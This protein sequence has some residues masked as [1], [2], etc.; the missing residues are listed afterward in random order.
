MNWCILAACL[1]PG[2]T[3]V[4]SQEHEEKP[5]RVA[6]HNRTVSLSKVKRNA[7]STV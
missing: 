4:I 3:F 2:K 5:F 6:P 7:Y 1:C